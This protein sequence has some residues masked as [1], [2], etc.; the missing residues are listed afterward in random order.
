MKEY[1]SNLP[2]ITLKY[3]KGETKKF[4]IERSVDANEVLTKL[5]DSDTMEISESFY[6]LFINRQNNTIGW[7]KHSSGGSISCLVDVRLIMVTALQ[8][9]ASSII[10]GHN[11]PSGNPTPSKSDIDLTLKIKTACEALDIRL[12]DHLVITESGKYYSFADNGGV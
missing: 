6:V 9:G 7:T 10:C 5:A 3:K 12:F 4:K 11:H 1:K 8:C 2:E